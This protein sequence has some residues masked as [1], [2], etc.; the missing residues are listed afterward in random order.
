MSVSG[1]VLQP[2]VESPARVSASAGFAVLIPARN[3]DATLATVLDS[4][5][6][7][8]HAPAQVIL[9]NDASTDTTPIVAGCYPVEQVHVS[10]A[11]GPMEARFAGIQAVSPGIPILVFVDADVRV[12]SDTFKRIL[13]HFEDPKVDAVTG[14]LARYGSNDRFFTTFKNEYMHTLFRKQPRRSRFIYGSIWAIRRES[15]VS[16]EPTTSPFGT[17]ASDSELAKILRRGGKRIVLD[18][19]LE[20]EHLK[21]YHL[22]SLLWNDF[23]IPFAFALLLVKYGWGQSSRKAGKFSHAS[24]GQVAANTLAFTGLWA[25]AA[26]LWHHDGGLLFYAL[27]ALSGKLF[28]WRNF[29]EGLQR[30]RGF[31]FALKAALFLP[32]DGAVMFCGMTAGLMYGL[33]RK[34]HQLWQAWDYK[35]RLR[36]TSL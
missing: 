17:P 12:A 4:I 2:E 29:L 23:K 14:L 1:S 28:Y 8:Q 3:A 9:I 19:A 22:G 13:E 30:R 11:R 33:G 20:V 34:V 15:L 18:H 7:A 25:L 6:R 10:L 31:V 24:L 35:N 32:L 21:R 16:F 5:F 26:G 36:K 27:C